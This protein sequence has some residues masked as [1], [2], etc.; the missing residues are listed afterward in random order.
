MNIAKFERFSKDK[1]SKQVVIK[2]EVR[3]EQLLVKKDYD[4][5]G[6][7]LEA[8][9]VLSYIDELERRVNIKASSSL[10][11]DLIESIAN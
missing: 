1:K 4:V 8:G 9:E 6:E 3:E 10:A 7:E 2:G 5:K 11:V